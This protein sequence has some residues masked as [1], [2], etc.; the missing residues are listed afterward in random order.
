MSRS[1]ARSGGAIFHLHFVR[2]CYTAPMSSDL[3]AVIKA[4]QAEIAKLQAEL[5]EARALL[6]SSPA[7]MPKRAPTP[8]TKARDQRR[9]HQEE[10]ARPRAEMSGMEVLAPDS[11]AYWA[12]QAIRTAGRPLHANDLVKAIEH[13]GHK[14][15]F[16][17]VVG[18]LS[19]WVKKR[20]VFYRAGR[21]VFGLIEM[22]KG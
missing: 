8:L 10:R 14:V 11:A 9:R 7:P 20:A 1:C 15:K 17:T 13:A 12:A 16:V 6:A 4:K 3:I 5:D 21:N 18:S 2:L 19:R 22:R